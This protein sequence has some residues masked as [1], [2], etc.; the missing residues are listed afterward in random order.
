[1][2]EHRHKA[3]IPRSEFAWRVAKFAA[4]ALAMVIGSL[5]IGILGYRNFEGMPWVDAFLNAAMIMG[6]M[7]PVGELHT[8][9]GKWF[10]GFYAL[11]CGM[12]FIVAVGIAFAPIFHRFLHHFHL[13][14]EEKDGGT[15]S[16]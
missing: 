14:I 4:V 7:G 1:M 15:D 10:A 3:L 6:G 12:V 16:G 9:G 8:R 5:A 13:E 2:F 11:Y